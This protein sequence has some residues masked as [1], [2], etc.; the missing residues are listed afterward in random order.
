MANDYFRF[1]R[2]L[3]RQD[4]CA[5]KVG[6]DGVLLGAW[7]QGGQRILDIGTGTGLI[8]LMMA[9]RFAD[10]HVDALEIDPAAA[11][12]ATENVA[13]S[14]FSQRITV[15]A[16]SVQQWAHD[17]RHCALYDAIVSN[18]PYFEQSLLSPDDAR[19]EARHAVT[20]TYTDL[21]SCVSRLLRPEGLF[22]VVIPFNCFSSLLSEAALHGFHLCRRC[23]IR[24]TPRK[25]P[26]RHL[27]TFTRAPHTPYSVEEGILETQPNVRSEWYTHLMRDFYL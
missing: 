16:L 19:T 11:A 26:R 23:D 20:L 5:M 21:F 2:F 7:A 3:V 1:R 9:Q 24:T 6:T 17:S 8:A 25:A 10:A 22:S 12:Q 14:P 4:C 13:A 18:P 27:L 15:T